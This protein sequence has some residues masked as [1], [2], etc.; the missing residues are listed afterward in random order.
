MT[1]AVLFCFLGR[2]C[3]FS[4]LVLVLP[5][6]LRFVQFLKGFQLGDRRTPECTM[7]ML[8]GVVKA[9]GGEPARNWVAS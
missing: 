3:C 9:D 5:L 7:V 8:N 6:Q 1:S 2:Y 4:T